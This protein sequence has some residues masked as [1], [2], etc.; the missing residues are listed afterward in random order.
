MYYI[1]R[2]NSIAQKKKKK[3]SDIYKIFDHVIDY[4]KSKGIY[5]EYRE[6]LEYAYA[7]IILCSSLIRVSKIG[8]RRIKKEQL[9]LA[10][11][12]LNKN[13]PDWKKNPILR[14]N[15]SGKNMYMRTINKI[16]FKIYPIFLKLKK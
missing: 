8:D 1:K 4:Y 15:K 9:N 7:R 6:G 2:N 12:E 10:W 5:E 16:T 3:V 11:K 14:N 13:F